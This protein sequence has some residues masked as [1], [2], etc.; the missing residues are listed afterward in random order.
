MKYAFSDDEAEIDDAVAPTRFHVLDRHARSI[1]YFD[2]RWLWGIVIISPIVFSAGVYFLQRMTLGSQEK[3]GFPVVEVRLVEQQAP[4]VLPP[5][6]QSNLTSEGRR[7]PLIEAPNKPIPE[8]TKTAALDPAPTPAVPIPEKSSATPGSRPRGTATGTMSAFQR[9]LLSHIARFRQYPAGA[10]AGQHGVTQLVFAMRRDGS[11]SEVWIRET[12]GSR[13]LDDAAA[14]IIR[15]A[16]PL[17]VIPTDLPD[18][19]TIRLPISFDPP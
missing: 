12:S 16:Q 13:L 1:P 17:P 2:T 18:Q 4:A 3:S 19:L 14:D 10:K 11:V 5:S 7:E 8:E 9:I 6:P 15:R